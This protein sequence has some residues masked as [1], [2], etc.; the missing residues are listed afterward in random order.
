M[1]IGIRKMLLCAIGL[2]SGLT[3]WP[4]A[5]LVLHFQESFSSYLLFTVV[6]G[7]TFGFVI[8]GVFG[9]RDGL[10]SGIKRHLLL[11]VIRGGLIGLVGGI[12]GFL[13][14]QLVLFLGG[15]YLIHSKVAYNTIALPLS[16]SAGWGVLGIFIGMID[17]LR[18]RSMIKFRA[19]IIGGLAGGIIGGAFLE[20][21]RLLL[22]IG[23]IARLTGFLIF[24]LS[25]GFFYSLVE[26]RLSYGYLKVL[27]GREKG[28]EFL[29][30]NNT[31]KIGKS[32]TN[33][34]I[35]G[36]Y[37]SIAPDHARISIINGNVVLQKVSTKWGVM[38][39]DQSVDEHMLKIDDVIQIGRAKLLYGYL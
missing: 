20:Y 36:G 34:I 38:A 3:V 35:L 19:G 8:G 15:E 26:E 14:G 25:I 13:C 22:P 16:R 12:I 17:G 11:G 31:I 39:N 5:E 6:L 29:V 4:F 32:T 1:T 28:R 27:N 18:S 33:D 2:I 37:A 9:S 23:I 24:G 21:M 30:S 7:A 10:F